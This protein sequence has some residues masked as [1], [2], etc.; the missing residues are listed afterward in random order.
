M[1][2]FF[3]IGI[4]ILFSCLAAANFRLS[5]GLLTVALPT[6]LLRGNIGPIPTTAL[7]IAFGAIALIWFIKYARADWPKLIETI[8]KQKLVF[9]FATLLLAGTFIAALANPNLLKALGLWR[10]YFLE[11]IVLFVIITARQIDYKFLRDS[12]AVSTISI[13]ALA[14]IQVV[15]GGPFPPSL[16]D[17][18]LFGRPTSFFTTPN[19]IGLFLTPIILLLVPAIARLTNKK[20]ERG[21]LCRA[22]IFILGT[23]AILA[24]FSQGAWAALIGGLL[25]FGFLNGKRKMAASIIVFGIFLVALIPSFRSAFLFQDQAGQNRLTL[26]TYS[27]E[28]LTDSPRQFV[29]GSG[30]RMFFNEVQR[31]HYNVEEMER[32]IYP[33]NIFL[34]FW[35][36]T[37]LIGLIAV[38][39]I[40]IAL[41]KCGW[42]IFKRDRLWGAAILGAIT[43]FI[44][45]G[46]V[47]VPYFKNDLA[48]M[49]WILTAVII[50]TKKSSAILTLA[51]KSSA[52]LTKDGDFV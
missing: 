25:V 18:E 4:F 34:N 1:Q 28:Y 15:F 42:Y 24:S 16:W 30:L 11:P 9:I 8:K 44:I 41:I 48:M 31:P 50:L 23:L 6:Y 10:A 51:K 20:P 5:V 37:G 46:L 14:I 26:W 36:E 40:L 12:L 22:G 47:D 29:L 3:L 45:H 49:F 32:L 27:M 19:A 39:G 38:I 17:D 13:S 43:A 52:I 2:I 33:H 7:E 35:L 21:D